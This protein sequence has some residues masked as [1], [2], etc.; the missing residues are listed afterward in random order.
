MAGMGGIIL[1]IVFLGAI[2]YFMAIR[3]QKKEE[4]NSRNCLQALLLVIRF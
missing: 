3:P 2:V 1:Y 4:K